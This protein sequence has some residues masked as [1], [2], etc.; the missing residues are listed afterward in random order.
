MGGR[1]S[2]TFEIDSAGKFGVFNGTTAIVP[3]LKAPGFC[4]AETENYQTFPDA[5]GFDN[6][7][8]VA[9][10]TS[11]SYAGFKLSLAADTLEPQ[12]KSFKA[13]FNLTS[14]K[15]ASE[16]TV[17]NI[18]LTSFSNDW[19]PYTGDCDTKD[20]TGTQH[21]CCS[22]DHPEVCAKSDDL[23]HIEQ[24]GI[25]SEGHEG[26]FHLEVLAVGVGK[27][28]APSKLAR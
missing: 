3:S 9:R 26:D 24:V 28:T 22:A 16:W 4:N 11:P 7:F 2:A 10:T 27:Y 6:V 8:I 18:P 5:S 15:S 14:A 23:K 21:H 13:N 17:V 20:P 25:W 12:F 1:S 19:S